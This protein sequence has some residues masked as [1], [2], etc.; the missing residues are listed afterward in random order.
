MSIRTADGLE[1]Y[2]DEVL[3]RLL[4]LRQASPWLWQKM[5]VQIDEASGVRG[6]SLGSTVHWLDQGSINASRLN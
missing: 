4:Q 5:A 3:N 6:L 2:K 1:D